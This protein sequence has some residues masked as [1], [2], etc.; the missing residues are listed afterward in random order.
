[1]GG[2]EQNKS[3]ATHIWESLADTNTENVTTE[4][5]E[6]HGTIPPLHQE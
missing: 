3:I 2:Y 6:S 5:Q 4:I 1:M